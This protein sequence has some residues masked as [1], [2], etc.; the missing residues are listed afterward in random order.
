LK[1]SPKAEEDQQRYFFRN[2]PIADIGEV[3][4]QRDRFAERTEGHHGMPPKWA[5]RS[6]RPTAFV[7]WRLVTT[8]RVSG[9]PDG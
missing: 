8:T 5:A 4:R 1:Y 9:P 3:G 7:Q 2:E 6:S